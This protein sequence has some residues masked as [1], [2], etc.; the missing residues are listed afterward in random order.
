M[1][2][3]ENPSFFTPFLSEI[4]DL[5]ALTGGEKEKMPKSYDE[6]Q[7]RIPS[8]K[9]KIVQ[10]LRDRGEEGATNTELVQI[11]LQYN[12]RLSELSKE[13]YIIETI[14]IKDGLYKYVLHKVPGNIVYHT[15]AL[16]DVL[17][18]AYSESNNGWIKVEKIPAIM[19]ENFCRMVRKPGYYQKQQ[20]PVFQEQQQMNL[21]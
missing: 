14:H 10:L 2:D 13:G 18:A 5:Y 16:T 17:I 6:A 7:T 4:E 19:A 15:D 3:F 1:G 21:F 20:Y 8:Q 12:S 11:S 9:L